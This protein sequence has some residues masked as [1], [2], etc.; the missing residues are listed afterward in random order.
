MFDPH[1][2]GIRSR[3]R[4]ERDGPFVS[5]VN[6]SKNIQPQKLWKGQAETTVSKDL[7]DGN[8]LFIVRNVLTQEQRV[9]YLQC[10]ADTQRVPSTIGNAMEMNFTRDGTVPA[11]ANVNQPTDTLPTHILDVSE[12]VSSSISSAMPGNIYTVLD[13]CA[14]IQLSKSMPNGGCLRQQ[15]EYASH[16]GCVS[17]LSFGQTRWMRVSKNDAQG[18]INVSM[19]DNTLL[20]MYGPTFQEHYKH[21]IDE[22][23]KAHPM[24]THHLL[25]MRFRRPYSNTN[26]RVS[27][28]SSL[29]SS[30]AWLKTAKKASN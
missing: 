28:A 15:S 4:Y 12:S 26:T 27:S 20:V 2:Q 9:S 22:L 6:E 24:G 18:T 3:E 11:Y 13:T 10:S 1:K 17:M 23:P 19:P 21:Q 25:K 30:R 7:G 14:E 5:H 29:P 8:H 16:W